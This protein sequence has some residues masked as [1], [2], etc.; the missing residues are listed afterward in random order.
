MMQCPWCR[1]DPRPVRLVGAIEVVGR[2]HSQN[3]L[4]GWKYNRRARHKYRAWR[5]DWGDVLAAKANLARIPSA[6]RVWR[7]VVFTRIVDTPR[8]LY[9]FGNLV[10]GLKPIV[11]AMVDVGLLVDDSPRWLNDH[12][13]QRVERLAPEALHIELWERPD[14]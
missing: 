8:M 2:V 9:D 6:K 7:R 11:D 14:E 4:H 3:V 10:G 12:Y 5:T 1:A 13:H